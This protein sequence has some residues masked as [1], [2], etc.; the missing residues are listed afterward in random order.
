MRNLL[1]SCACVIAIGCGESHVA[2]DVDSGGLGIDAGRD[3]TPDSSVPSDVDSG[4]GGDLDGGPPIVVI[5][6]GGL[7]LDSSTPSDVDAGPPTGVDAGPVGVTCGTETCVDPQ[8]C[9]VI[10]GAGGIM[11]QSCTAADACDGIEAACDGPED[12][13]SGE[14]C[15]GMRTPGGGGSASCVDADAMC[16]LRVCH[17]DADCG[18]G[19]MCCP[20]MGT[21]VCSPFGCGP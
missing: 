18:D 9:C 15:C 3:G 17:A 19:A 4:G 10:A 21:G 2:G 8:I 20:F 7:V 14:V 12:C 16:L 1:L 11:S 13:A 5:D 6:G